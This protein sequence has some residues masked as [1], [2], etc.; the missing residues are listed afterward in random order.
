MA[1]KDKHTKHTNLATAGGD[2]TVLVLLTAAADDVVATWTTDDVVS[3]VFSADVIW[4]AG[5]GLPDND[6]DGSSGSAAK[7][8]ICDNKNSKCIVCHF[9]VFYSTNSFH[10][11][12]SPHRLA[13]VILG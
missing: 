7:P 1:K 2:C 10:L 11:L 9:K 13:D 5:G 3:L 6:I 4:L 12:T 8:L